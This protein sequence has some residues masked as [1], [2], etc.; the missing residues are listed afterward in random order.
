MTPNFFDKLD[1]ASRDALMAGRADPG[2]AMLVDTMAALHSDTAP[3]E[4]VVAGVMLEVEAPTCMSAGALDSVL[5]EIDALQDDPAHAV[6]A[7]AAAGALD[8]LIRLPAPLR[9]V[10]LEASAQSGWKFASP[11][12]RVIDLELGGDTEVQ[13]MRL[14]PGQSVPRHT[15]E[16][17]EYTLCLAGGFSDERGS[18][19]PGELSIADGSV[20]HTPIADQDGVCIVLAVNDAG[21]KFTG[22]L[23]VLQRIF[24]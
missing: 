10:A 9:D 21:L 18:Y 7:K 3:L 12:I 15:H 6:A 20:V 14:Q 23:G 5:A 11:G 13:L 1:A 19:G 2:V 17:R 22:I 8:E 16:G 24:S 4:D